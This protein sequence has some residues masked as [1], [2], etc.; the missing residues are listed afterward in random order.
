MS[1]A[2]DRIQRR[3]HSWDRRTWAAVLELE[4]RLGKQVRIF[5]GSYNEGVG[6][7]AGTHDGGGAIDFWVDGVSAD[8]VTK[9]ARKVGWA[10][11]WR[12]P[13]QGPWPDHQHA[14]LRGHDTAAPIAKAQC[15]SYDQG[16]TGLAAGGPD[17]QPWRPSAPVR[18]SYT[19]W[20]KEQTLRTR[21]RRL[22][23]SIRGY[24]N[25]RRQARQALARLS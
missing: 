17:P 1:G 10:C 11:W 23:R 14:I 2:Y 3:G 12:K 4:E 21:I 9:A 7:S 24:R 8:Q 6:V 18:F 5:Q 15:L 25:R 16:G 13:S 19:K 20:V 22:T